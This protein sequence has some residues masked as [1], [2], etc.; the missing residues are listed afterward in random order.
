MSTTYTL[1]DV[2][3]GQ[4]AW[5]MAQGPDGAVSHGGMVVGAGVAD[6]GAPYLLLLDEGATKLCVQSKPQ[7]SNPW[8]THRP[9]RLV[10]LRPDEIDTL[11]VRQGPAAMHGWARKA[12]LS[13]ALGETGSGRYLSPADVELVDVALRLRTESG[14]LG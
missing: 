8:R 14:V 7:G 9:A 5:T 6:G 10:R 11:D 12:L 2:A 13:A 3:V 4:L 1:D